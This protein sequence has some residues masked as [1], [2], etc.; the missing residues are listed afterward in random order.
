LYDGTEI[1]GQDDCGP[2]TFDRLLRSDPI[3]VQAGARL[4]LRAAEGTAFSVV[5]ARLR[6]EW[7]VTLA[8]AAEVS[9]VDHDDIQRFPEGFGTIL[10]HGRGPDTAV[11]ITM[12]TR[13]GDYVVQFDGPLVTSGWTF[14]DGDYYWLVR[15]V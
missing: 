1:Y 11:V 10:A 6:G 2:T 8:R 5:A 12:P 15:V 7:T 13:A 4:V 14:T 9:S 3:R